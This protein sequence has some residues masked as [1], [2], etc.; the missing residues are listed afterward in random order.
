MQPAV[1]NAETKPLNVKSGKSSKGGKS[2]W[3]FYFEDRE[4]GIEEAQEVKSQNDAWKP[5]ARFRQRGCK[6]NS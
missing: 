2:V 5:S 1:K 6:K 4:A 3:I